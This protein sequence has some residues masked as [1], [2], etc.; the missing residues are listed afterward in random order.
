MKGG[1]DCI[2]QRIVYET[3]QFIIKQFNFWFL[4]IR[5]CLW[6]SYMQII[7][8]TVENREN[9]DDFELFST[10][11]EFIQAEAVG[12]YLLKLP[13]KKF[14]ELVD[15]YYIPKIIKNII[16]IPLLLE[17]GFEIK[18]KG[19]SCSIYFSDEFYGNWYVDNGLTFFSLNDNVFH[20]NEN[21]KKKKRA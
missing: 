10:S 20:I 16:S 4:D 6:F 12:T 5:Y 9:K 17:Q 13:S 19:K 18:S 14:L 3:N 2:F 1:K 7:A 15:C 11:G 8:R 21:W